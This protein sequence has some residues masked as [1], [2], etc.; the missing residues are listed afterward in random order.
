MGEVEQPG[1][2]FMG[3]LKS[4]HKVEQWSSNKESGAS[5][6]RAIKSKVSDR[7]DDE[8]GEKAGRM[9]EITELPICEKYFI[10][11]TSS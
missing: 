1:Y 5:K 11:T 10:I 4:R 3:T 2:L 8:K 7:H 6:F 9:E